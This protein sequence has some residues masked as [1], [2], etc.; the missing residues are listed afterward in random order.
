MNQKSASWVV[1]GVCCEY[2]QARANVGRAAMTVVMKV[3]HIEVEIHFSK[4]E[5]VSIVK[6]LGI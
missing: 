5:D 3:S 1:P 4:S 2:C 6:R